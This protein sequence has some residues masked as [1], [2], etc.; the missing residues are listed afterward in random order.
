M[1]TFIGTDQNETITPTTVSPTVTVFGTPST[2]SPV[3]DVI[4]SGGGNDTVAGGGGDDTAFLGT[5]DDIFIWNPGDG[6]DVVEGQEGLDTLEFNGSAANETID[7]SANG[8]RSRFLRD[9]ANITM[10]MDR[11]ERIEF[12]ALGGLDQIVINDLSGTDVAE[13][14]LDLAGTPGGTT[15][16]GQVDR[17]TLRGAE[18]GES[19]Q[20]QGSSTSLIVEGLAAAVSAVNADPT[21]TLLIEARGGDD[22]IS[23]ANLPAGIVQLSIDAGAGNDRVVG[24]AGVELVLAGDGNDTA[25]GGRGDDIGFMGAGDD[26]FIWN[27]GDGSDVVEGQ[28]G[29]DTLDFNGAGANETIDIT[30]NGSRAR[31]FRDVAAVTMDLNDVERIDFAALGGTDTIR[32]GDLTGTAVTRVD[33]DLA[34][35]AGTGIGD[36]QADRVTVNGNDGAN[37]ITVRTL[38]GSTVVSGLSA[39]VQMTGEDAGRDVLTIE[40]GAGNDRISAARLTDDGMKFVARGEAGN[41]VI[42]GGA[43]RDSLFGDSGNDYLFGARANDALTGGSGADRFA[44]AGR[45]GTDRIKDFADGVDRIRIENYGPA[46]NSFSDLA[47]DIVQV[48]ANVH[49]R[50]GASVGGAGTII[51]EKFTVAQ[52]SAADFQFI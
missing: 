2:P 41:D 23:A 18:T 48:G 15:G 9:V 8:E 12:D 22:T 33:L 1:S 29:L 34:G 50:L 24:S 36:G 14:A 30:A 28:L 38:A 25:T 4:V 44:F 31:F 6:S 43:G 27:P 7:I 16:D 3:A 40:A 46:L 5:G 20:I 32:V 52:L 19:I 37:G 35:S 49:I 13:V 39:R 51:V 42:R 17:V 47:D 26:I 10:D 21:D 45:N 11:V